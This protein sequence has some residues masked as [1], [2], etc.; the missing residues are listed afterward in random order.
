[1]AIYTKIDTDACISCGAC[2]AEAPNVY[3]MEDTAVSTLDDNLGQV[4]VPASEVDN[5]N[6]ANESCPVDAVLVQETPF[7]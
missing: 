7:A 2:V 1:M 5:V 3:D 6:S 4:E